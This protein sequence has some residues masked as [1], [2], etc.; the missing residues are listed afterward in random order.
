MEPDDE[1]EL[2]EEVEDE[3]ALVDELLPKLF[4]GFLFH[5][6]RNDLD[7]PEPPLPK[8]IGDLAFE[9]VEFQEPGLVEVSM[10]GTVCQN[11]QNE[12]VRVICWA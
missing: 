7:P 9:R 5:H 4:F 2:A 6:L 11:F 8:P 3:E 10:E 1:E 12:N